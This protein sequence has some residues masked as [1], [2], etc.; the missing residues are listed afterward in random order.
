MTTSGDQRRVFVEG[1]P[2]D[3]FFALSTYPSSLLPRG[4][5]YSPTASASI[6]QLSSPALNMWSQKLHSPDSEKSEAAESLLPSDE[7]PPHTVRQTPRT[8]SLRYVIL[9]VISHGLLAAVG[10]LVGASWKPDPFVLAAQ[11]T[12]RYCKAS[13][14]PRRCITC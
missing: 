3:S 9:L 14:A 4:Q 5:T 13:K 6:E 11:I 10:L 7:T 8:W 1:G 2:L 12:A